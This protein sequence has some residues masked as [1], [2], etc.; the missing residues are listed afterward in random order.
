MS[1]ETKRFPTYTK[2][3]STRSPCAVETLAYIAPT[4]ICF[5]N[6]TDRKSKHSDFRLVAGTN[7]GDNCPSVTIGQSGENWTMTCNFSSKTARVTFGV[8]FI[9]TL[10]LLSSSA[11][12][13]QVTSG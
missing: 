5:S 7:A 2:V 8:L 1:N 4:I 6:V 9:S 11:L 12:L 3:L 10:L 13:A